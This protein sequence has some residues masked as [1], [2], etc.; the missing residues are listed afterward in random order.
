MGAKP[1]LIL[2]P[3][4]FANFEMGAVWDLLVPI[5]YDRDLLL[6]SLTEWLGPPDGLRILDCAC[7]SGFPALDLHLLGYDLVCTDVFL[8]TR[9]PLD[10]AHFDIVLCRGCSLIYAGTWECKPE[11]LE[12]F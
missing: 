4:D 3:D 7:G 2:T 5:E 10:A 11:P 1:P 6:Q 8:G 12:A 9:S